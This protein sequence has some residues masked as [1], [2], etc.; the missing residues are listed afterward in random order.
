MV[1]IDENV[2]MELNVESIPKDLVVSGVSYTLNKCCIGQM[3]LQ[4]GLARKSKSRKILSGAVAVAGNAGTVKIPVSFHV[5][6]RLVSP[7]FQSRHLCVYYELSFTIQFTNGGLL[8]SNPTTEFTVPIGITNLPHNHL[9]HI[10]NLTSVQSY[11]QSKESPIFF[12]PDLDEPPTQSSIPSE[13]WGPL[14]AAL[15]TPPITSP[16][17]YFS[18]SDLPQQFIQKD[19]EEKVVFT[20]R[21]IRSGMAQELGDPITVVSEHRDY[22]W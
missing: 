12:D 16:P 2:D 13:L 22:E 14:T 20:S 17:N 11:L 21:L 5:P 7:S 6:T 18:L 10:P 15:T 3:Q 19:R 9:L 1:F 8:K 4:R